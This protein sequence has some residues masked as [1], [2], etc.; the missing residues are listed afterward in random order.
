[1]NKPFGF[2]KEVVPFYLGECGLYYKRVAFDNGYAVSIVS[3]AH[4]YGG[5]DGLFEVAVM[6]ADTDQIVYDAPTSTP[7]DVSGFLDFLEVGDFLASIKALPKRCWHCNPPA[8]S[9]VL[10]P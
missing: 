8:Y 1:M 3:H 5:H 9:P 7:S 2:S 10:Q 4:S 6:N